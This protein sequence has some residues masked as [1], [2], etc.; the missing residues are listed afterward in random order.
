MERSNQPTEPECCRR[1]GQ[2]SAAKE[3]GEAERLAGGVPREIREPQAGVAHR[4][5]NSASKPTDAGGQ[6][7]L[8][9]EPEI[10]SAVKGE[11][12]RSLP[13]SK[14]VAREEGTVRNQGDPGMAR[15]GSGRSQALQ[16]QRSRSG[17]L[18][19]AQAFSFRVS[20]ARARA[21]STVWRNTVGIQ[22]GDQGLRAGMGMRGA[23]DSGCY[24]EIA[25]ARRPRHRK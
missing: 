24:A 16:G 18:S 9:S 13:G 14:S 10:R 8:S 11:A 20:A 19:Y 5:S 3:G 22:R 6:D 17:R 4:L 23:A 25:A 15:G 21:S 1:E 12:P 2:A 7:V